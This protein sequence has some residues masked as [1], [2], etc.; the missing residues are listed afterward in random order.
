MNSSLSVSQNLLSLVLLTIKHF[1]NYQKL[2]HLASFKYFCEINDLRNKIVHKT[3]LKNIENFD[4]K[5]VHRLRKRIKTLEKNSSFIKLK[6]KNT[7]I[8]QT[9]P[10]YSPQK[11]DGF[12]II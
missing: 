5:A 8:Q 7:K 6:K 11:I 2:K 4:S 10:R 1:V 9:L 3:S 12:I